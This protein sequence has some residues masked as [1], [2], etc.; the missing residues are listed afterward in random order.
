MIPLHS[1]VMTKRNLVSYFQ[2]SKKEFE[3]IPM[4]LDTQKYRTK[5]IRLTIMGFNIGMNL[6]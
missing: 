2:C 1:L 5:D 6:G 3:E 4:I